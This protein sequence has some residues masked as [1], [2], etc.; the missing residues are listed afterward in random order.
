MVPA[1][2][3]G[4]LIGLGVGWTFGP[5]FPLWNGI[6]PA[7]PPSSNSQPRIDYGAIVGSAEVIHR[8]VSISDQKTATL[9]STINGLGSTI[10][11][12][13]STIDGLGTEFDYSCEVLDIQQRLNHLRK[14][15]QEDWK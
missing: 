8:E 14:Q 13:G 15:L 6:T 3:M 2:L 10:D 12:L 9:G 4:S 7:G 5:S 11:S 1:G